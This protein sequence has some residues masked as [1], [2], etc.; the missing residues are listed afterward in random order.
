MV[1]ID[2]NTTIARLNKKQFDFG[3]VFLIVFLLLPHSCFLFYWCISAAMDSMGKKME[4][5]KYTDKLVPSTRF[6]AVEGV[7]AP[8]VNKMSFV[9]PTACVIGDVTVGKESR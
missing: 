9:A 3:Y 2:T 5:T 8:R 1:F 6:V 4:I 7:G